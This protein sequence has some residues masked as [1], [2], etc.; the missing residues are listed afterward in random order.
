LDERD[1][2][3]PD[4]GTSSVYLAKSIDQGATFS[5]NVRIAEQ[6]CPCCRPT[7]AFGPPGKVF[8]ASRRVFPGEI[9]DMVVSTSRDGGQTFAQPVRVH[10]DGW[11]LN[12]CPDSGPALAESNGNLYTV[13]MTEGQEA[14]PSMQHTHSVDGARSFS[15]P[16]DISGDV[17]DPNH[18]VLRTESDGTTWLVFQ[19]RASRR[20]AVGIR[21][22]PMWF[23][24]TDGK[25]SLAA[26]VPG[27]ENSIT[28]PRLALG[29]RGRTFL[30]WTQPE[31]NRQ[32]VI[33][34]GGRTKHH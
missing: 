21:L 14:R 20:T 4:Q 11:K 12:G 2:S 33:L 15:E 1:N 19:G 17:L 32:T 7:L 3:N 31:G 16:R 13:W 23:R 24:W 27:S 30:A 18:P 10:D 22:K 34:S 9:R 6:A 26:P 29:S 28:Y 5:R 8:V 25:P